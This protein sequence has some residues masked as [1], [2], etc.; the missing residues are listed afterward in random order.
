MQVLIA[1]EP[2]LLGRVLH[3][4]ASVM[5][6]TTETNPSGSPHPSPGLLDPPLLPEAVLPEP[7]P[8]EPVPPEPVI[9]VHATAVIISGL[10]NLRLAAHPRPHHEPCLAIAWEH[11]RERGP[12]RRLDPERMVL[13]KLPDCGGDLGRPLV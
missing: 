6:V 7:V 11:G 5:P 10:L 4:V 12:M 3:V 2:L 1:D 8:P 13:G 9:T